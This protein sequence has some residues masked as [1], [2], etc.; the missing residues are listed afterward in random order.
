MGAMGEKMG[1]TRGTLTLLRALSEGPSSRQRLL[2]ALEDAGIYRDE[3][4]I[5]RW[6][7]VL[8]EAGFGIERSRGGYELRDSPVRIGFDKYEALATLSVLESLADRE[9]LY[10]KHLAS[11]AAKLREALPKEALRFADSGK[12][13]FALDSASDPP[14]DPNVMDVL[15][16]AAHRS[17]RAE[18]LYHSLRS[19]EV[20]WRTVEPVRVVY[21]QRGHRLYAYEQDENRVTEFRVNRIRKAKMLPNKFS[22]EAH[23]RS[24][25]PAKVR[26]NEKAFI[27]YGKSIVP[28]HD[29]TI[30]RLEDGGAIITGTTPSVFWTV[31]EIAALG[32]DA[33]VLGGPE[34]KKE[35]LSFLRE[36]LD[37]YE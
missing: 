34:L 33:Q 26:L 9:P 10:G 17:Q 6:L 21:V 22:P 2:E 15:R 7:K 31:R 27:A 8:R 12:I 35:L 4:T 5:R 30:E 28:D 14:E 29:A 37:K 25:E 1:A 20:R 13:E 24:F 36:T 32:P 19:N 11:A 16:R 3:R 18:I 23:A